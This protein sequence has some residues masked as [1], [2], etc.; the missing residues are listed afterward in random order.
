MSPLVLLMILR[1]FGA[2]PLPPPYPLPI[3]P[4]G[5]QIMKFGW[6]YKRLFRGNECILNVVS[7]IPTILC[8]PQCDNV[9]PMVG[10]FFSLC[11]RH[12][13]LQVTCLP[14]DS[15]TW[16]I[17]PTMPLETL[18]LAASSCLS[19]V[20]FTLQQQYVLLTHWG[21]VTHIYASKLTTIGPDNGLSPRRH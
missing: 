1:W 7:N 12:H 6:K 11:R 17:P 2:K 10:K 20:S 21:R 18:P 19:F 9:I 16:R 4:L 5:R 15:T 14:T 13:F 8:S 3:G